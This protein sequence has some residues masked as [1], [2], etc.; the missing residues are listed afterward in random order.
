MRKSR[1]FPVILFLLSIFFLPAKIQAQNA[2]VNILR[3]INPMYPTSQYW[4]QTSSS[5]Y[6]VP[7]AYSIGLLTY[8]LIAHDPVEKKRGCQAL[9][10]VGA[11]IAFTEI[12]KPVIHRDRPADTY[13]GEIFPNSPAHGNSFPSGHTTLAFAAAATIAMQH[14][15]WYIAVPAYLWAA[16]VGYSRMYL[17]KHYP[18]DVLAGAAVGI[19]GAYLGRWLT[20][21][22]FRENRPVNMNK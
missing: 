6:W 1:F 21:K 17:G 22:I 18:S 13:P 12:L 3:G 15:Q 4:I 7:S 11:A 16:S 9:I 2:D 20:K 19:G 10:S 14:K 8:G 5:A